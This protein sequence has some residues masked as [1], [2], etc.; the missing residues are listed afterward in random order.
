MQASFLWLEAPYT[1]V[2]CV[3]CES[4]KPFTTD[5]QGKRSAKTTERSS[6]NTAHDEPY[7]TTLLQTRLKHGSSDG[8][9]AVH[10]G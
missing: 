8:T 1:A 2:L 6:E 3:L 9:T 10:A 7:Y 5:E 4:P